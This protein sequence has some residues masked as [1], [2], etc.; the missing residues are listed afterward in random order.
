MGCKPVGGLD[1]GIRFCGCGHKSPKL[2]TSKRT[3]GLSNGFAGNLETELGTNNVG[4][5][6]GYVVDAVA[7]MAAHHCTWN[8]WFVP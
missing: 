4:F 6:D 7:R 3:G 1:W 8:P 2:R 5:R